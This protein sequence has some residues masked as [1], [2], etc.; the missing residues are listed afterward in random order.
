MRYHKGN[1]KYKL[2]VENELLFNTLDV[3]R[4]FSATK[5]RYILLVQI[6]KEGWD[7]PSLTGIILSQKGDSPKNMVLQ[8]SCRCLRQ[9]DKG[10]H[11][12][13]MIW[14]NEYNAKV[15]NEQLKKEQQTSIE[16]LNKLDRKT[17]PEQ[18][19]RFSRIE[20]LQLPKVEF[21]QLQITYN[22]INEEE[23]PNT[24]NKFQN[25]LSEIDNYKTSALIKT[26]ELS[27][28]YDA[29]IKMIE[30]TGTSY[31]NF[32]QWIFEISKESYNKI[33]VTDLNKFQTE[34]KQIFRKITFT[35][36]NTSFFNELYDLY[37]INSQIRISFSII[38][39]L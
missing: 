9:V 21:Y 2:P 34:L 11:E 6:G 37:Q 10:E 29:D 38:R 24:K 23:K 5:K 12:T 13:A 8:T 27:N 26:S 20:H 39:H 36:N 17:E 32:N 1:K 19:E 4:T 3:P 25:L 18:I 31:A 28:I 33:S 30:Q 22:S 7:S 15:L 35:K 14:L 16:E